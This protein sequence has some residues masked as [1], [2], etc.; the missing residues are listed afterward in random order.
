MPHQRDWCSDQSLHSPWFS[1]LHYLEH[2]GWQHCPGSASDI[3]FRRIGQCYQSRFGVA[4]TCYETDKAVGRTLRWAVSM[5]T[6]SGKLIDVRRGRDIHAAAV[7]ARF[8]GTFC[9]SHWNGLLF[10]NRGHRYLHPVHRILDNENILSNRFKPILGDLT[11]VM[12][13]SRILGNTD[14]AGLSALLNYLR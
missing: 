10:H 2:R 6:Y 7:E 8:K 1:Q 3:S 12:V 5:N 14:I 4:P 13:Y 9:L 11:L